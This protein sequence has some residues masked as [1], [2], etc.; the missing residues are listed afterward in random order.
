M[1]RVLGIYNF[2]VR[3]IV[4]ELHRLEGGWQTAI[5]D[6]KISGFEHFIEAKSA[7]TIDFFLHKLFSFRKKYRKYGYRYS[8]KYGAFWG[9]PY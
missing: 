4:V 2:G 7:S 9:S 1:F 3:Q 5:C 8:K 6:K